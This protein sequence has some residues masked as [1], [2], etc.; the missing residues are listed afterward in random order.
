MDLRTHLLGVCTS[1]SCSLLIQ[2][3]LR[4]RPPTSLRGQCT[5]HSGLFDVVQGEWWISRHAL[6]VYVCI[7]V[8][9]LT[10]R[11]KEGGE[12][13]E[14]DLLVVARARPARRRRGRRTW[15]KHTRRHRES[16]QG[17]VPR[18]SLRPA[19]TVRIGGTT[20]VTAERELKAKKEPRARAQRARTG[21]G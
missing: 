5:I 21:H 6:P 13:L 10:S 7:R 11:R 9:A 1:P 8:L 18:Q 16:F 19:L 14:A 20:A 17:S 4:K 12:D 2:V 3:E 15:R